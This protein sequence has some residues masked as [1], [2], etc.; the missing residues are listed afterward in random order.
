MLE[1]KLKFR[2]NYARFWLLSLVLFLSL[3]LG[4]PI[5]AADPISLEAYWQKIEETQAEVAGLS[6]AASPEHQAKLLALAEEW[7]TIT[8]VTLPNGRIIPVESTFLASQLRADPPNPARLKTLLATLL[9]TRSTWPSPRHSAADVVRLETILARPE[10]QWPAEAPP[11]PLRR[12]LLQLLQYLRDLIAYFWPESDPTSVSIEPSVFQYGWTIVM[13]LLLLLIVAFIARSL[14]ADLVS[15]AEAGPDD[16]L[17]REVLTAGTAFTKA[18]TLSRAGDYRT[19]VRYLYLSSLL[20]LDERGLLSYN[21]SQTNREYLRSV[22]HLP[23]LA[24]LLREVIE[25]FDRVWYGY[26]PLDETTYNQYAARVA[27]LHRQ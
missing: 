25:V 5:Q 6:D 9:A 17:E 11:S 26:Q 24:M 4:S 3:A 18:Q 10:F 19:A 2:P 22:A 16:P 15:Q 21:R 12:W 23:L 7:E 20:H 14:L 27:E 8:R 13:S 1:L